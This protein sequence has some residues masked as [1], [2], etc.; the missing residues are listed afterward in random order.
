MADKQQ[1]CAHPR[2]CPERDDFTARVK[3]EK[4]ALEPPPPADL[5][6]RPPE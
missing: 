4:L 3:T 5:V 1:P 6:P 2:M